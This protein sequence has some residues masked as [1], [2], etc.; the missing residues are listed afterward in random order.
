MAKGEFV[1]NIGDD[2]VVLTR[3][4]DG[5]VANAWLGSPDPALA[6]EELG[7]AL[8]TDTKGRISVLVDTLDQ[9]FKEEELP[10]VGILDRRKVLSRH[11]AMAF[12][13]AN[14]RGAHL[15]GPGSK[16]TLLYQFAAVPLDGRIPG[17]MDFVDS[18]PNQKGG[19]FAVAAENVDLIAALAPKDAPPVEQGNHWRHLIGINV[20]GGLRQII[21][22][23]GRL[24]LTRLTQA[25]PPETPPDEFADMIIRDFR[26][27]IT[28]IRRLGYA[29]GDALDLVV[30]TTPENKGALDALTWDGARS[31]SIYTPYEA[32][33]TIGVGSI[34]KE[35]QAYCD[36]LHAAWFANKGRTR[37]PLTRSAALG[38]AKDDLRELAFAVAPYAAG[39][40]AAAVVGWTGWAGYD[41][42]V[43]SSANAQME[44]QLAALKHTLAEEQAKLGLLPYDAARM[45]NVLEVN[46]SLEIGKL[47]Y[48]PLFQTI[49]SAL[50]NDAVVLSAK[51]ST[52]GADPNAPPQPG[53]AASKSAYTI[54]VNMR[55]ADVITRAD[56][57]VQVARRLEARL[58]AGFGKGHTV[59]MT[60]EPV[61]AQASQALTGNLFSSEANATDSSSQGNVSRDEHFFVEFQITKAG[62]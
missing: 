49:S 38:T 8:A 42:F 9:S 26:A 7:E 61:A 40:L 43:T 18:L 46:S 32:G 10:K 36:V 39:L 13:G 50:Q 16:N 2:N 60:K 53:G 12:P 31:V 29:V 41:T 25:P 24:C 28:Y 11:I 44:Q 56:E 20:T 27:T 57:A 1:L 21:E 14:M 17:W 51:F 47:D 45:R 59:K 5:G 30:L 15:I 3:L 33:A 34:G 37:L 52:G 35:D 55:L 4:V 62:P 23:N 58:N 54:D 22:K 6:I 48:A 19:V